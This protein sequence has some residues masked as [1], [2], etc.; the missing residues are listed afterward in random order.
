MTALGTAG[1][2]AVRFVAQ[3]VPIARSCSRAAM[4]RQSAG[5]SSIL[6]RSI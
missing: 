1:T 4:L 2:A 6:T 3:S 5:R